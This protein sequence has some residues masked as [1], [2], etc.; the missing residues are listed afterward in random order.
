MRY[1]ALMNDPDISFGSI[2][3]KHKW[4][5]IR[6][7]PGRYLLSGGLSER[8]PGTL[9]GVDGEFPEQRSHA[10][11]DPVVVISFSGGGLISFHRP[12]GQW[13]HTL[14]TS[15]GFNRKVS[16]LGLKPGFSPR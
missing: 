14:N 6:N 5:E 12:D 11:V 1:D 2:L 10:A 3:K 4:R 7:C 15:A 16:D 9:L 8:A 13:I